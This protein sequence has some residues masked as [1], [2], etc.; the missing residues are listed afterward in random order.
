M[1]CFECG[2]IQGVEVL[3]ACDNCNKSDWFIDY[4]DPLPWTYQ[5]LFSIPVFFYQKFLGFFSDGRVIR[6][7]SCGDYF[8]SVLCGKCE[9]WISG[10]EG[11]VG[12]TQSETPNFVPPCTECG[13]TIGGPWLTQPCLHC[14]K[15]SISPNEEEADLRRRIWG[16]EGMPNLSNT[17]DKRSNLKLFIDLLVNVVLP[18]FVLQNLHK[19]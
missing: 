13:E 1:R 17:E 11:F 8:D 14:G 16:K 9:A 3:G 4:P 10:Y 12:N 2:H 19:V 6:C 7:R 15:T 5:G 18:C